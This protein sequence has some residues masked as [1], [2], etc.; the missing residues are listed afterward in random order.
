MPELEDVEQ[1][2]DDQWECLREALAGCLEEALQDETEQQ[3]PA[4]INELR[5]K[6]HQSIYD[7]AQVTVMEVCWAMR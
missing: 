4:E 5:A 7:N 2:V 3:T 6:L 1:E